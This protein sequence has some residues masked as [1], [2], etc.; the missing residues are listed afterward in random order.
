VIVDW[1]LAGYTLRGM[2]LE[3]EDEDHRRELLRQLTPTPPTIIVPS[4]RAAS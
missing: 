4:W 2:L 1:E 3:A